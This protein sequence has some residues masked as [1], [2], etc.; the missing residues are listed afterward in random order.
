[1]APTGLFIDGLALGE[2]RRIQSLMT[3][4]GCNETNPAVKVDVVVTTHELPPP[5]TGLI[6]AGKALRRIGWTVLTSAKQGFGIRVIVAGSGS[7]I[8]GR[9]AQAVEGLPQG[10]PLH[11]T[12][13]VCLQHQ[14][15]VDTAFAEHGATHHGGRV[16]GRLA[17]I[18]FPATDLPAIEIQDQVEV[19]KQPLDR[20]R[21]PANIP[22]PDVVGGA[23]YQS[24]RL[25]RGAGPPAP[26][27]MV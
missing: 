26:A 8:G 1:M 18:H 19:E 4:L 3:L 7:A 5:S 20:S 25:H 27:P 15:P 13:V 14:G 10:L 24:W 23:G 9:D 21:Q 6:Q 11:R 17:R 16:L 2:N 12:A 22:G